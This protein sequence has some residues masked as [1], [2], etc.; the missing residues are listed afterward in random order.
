LI[1]YIDIVFIL[2]GFVLAFLLGY[3]FGMG[4]RIIKQFMEKF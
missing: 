1:E 4:L 2:G 3:T